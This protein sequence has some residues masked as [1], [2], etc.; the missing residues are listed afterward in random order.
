[1]NHTHQLSKE[2]YPLVVFW[3]RADFTNA[4]SDLTTISED[5]ESAKLAFL[6]HQNGDRFTAQEEADTR[7]HI[8]AAFVSLLEK[9][10]APLTW[11]Q[12]SSI[13]VNWLRT[14]MLTYCPDL[15]LCAM[16][17]KVDAL[18]TEVYSQWSHYRRDEIQ[19]HRPAPANTNTNGKRKSGKSESSI[20]SKKRKPDSSVSKA[21]TKTA[22]TTMKKPTRKP[23][24]TSAPNTAP[25]AV[26]SAS[27]T[28]SPANS[29]PMVSN[30]SVSVIASISTALATTVSP[31]ST[32]PS[33]SSSVAVADS[34][35]TFTSNLP[36]LVSQSPT[37]DEL[38]LRIPSPLPPSSDIHVE[39]QPDPKS[40]VNTHSDPVPPR[41]LPAA[42][43]PVI[44]IVN[45]LSGL[46]GR[47]PAP[48]VSR[49]KDIVPP[50]SV[51]NA[52]TPAPG[53]EAQGTP[54][55]PLTHQPNAST[56][57]PDVQKKKPPHRPGT[58]HTAWNLFGREHMKTNPKDIITIVQAAFAALTPERLKHYKDE[59]ARLKQQKKSTTSTD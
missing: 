1:M 4:D 54:G 39:D 28:T 10:L 46:L 33:T 9:Q 24:P 13:A 59:A 23:S 53:V 31:Q 26:T 15:G 40:A 34:P 19:S 32:S 36:D 11:S 29:S 48:H 43:A 20:A 50:D 37:S 45:P 42:T 6:E 8:R 14:E 41:I 18:A 44:K 2:D 38:P 5:D 27:D 12:A 57:A 55:A 25:V 16:N 47:A 51:G 49:I 17:W 22:S 52:K 58:A 3:D 35:A 21:S 30:S 56:E 7:A